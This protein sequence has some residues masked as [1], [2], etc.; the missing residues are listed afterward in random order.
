MT[1][2][3]QIHLTHWRL[4]ASFAT[5]TTCLAYV[6]LHI[7]SLN[8][9]ID[10]VSPEGAYVIAALRGHSPVVTTQQASK[11][12][13]KSCKVMI[14]V[15]QPREQHPLQWKDTRQSQSL[16]L[17][18]SSAATYIITCSASRGSVYTSQNMQAR[19]LAELLQKTQNFRLMHACVTCRQAQHAGTVAL[20]SIKSLRPLI[21]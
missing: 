3:P 18:V 16:F 19:R 5:V 20:I 14:V 4:E 8:L 7:W 12:G 15:C 6:F 11:Q 9:A 10:I 21:V 1:R 13:H 2:Q 17:C